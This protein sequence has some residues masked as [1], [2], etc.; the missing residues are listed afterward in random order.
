[1]PETLS[2]PNCGAPLDYKGSDPIIRC[3]Y[4]NTSVVVPENLR[5]KPSFSSQPHNFTL[6]GSGDMAGLIQKARRI[7]EVRDLAQSGKMDEAVHLY[8]EITDSSETDAQAAVQALSQGRPITLTGFSAVDV[9]AQVMSSSERV[10]QALQM[11]AETEKQT[12]RTGCLVGCFITGL[13]VFILAMVFIPIFGASFAT[14]FADNKQNMPEVLLTAM[15][16]ISTSMPDIIPTVHTFAQQD[17]SFGGE[18]TGAGLF[19]DP[20]AIAV[21]SQSG[22]IYVADYQGGRVQAFD[23]GGKFLTQWKVGDKKTII[24]SLAADHKG[25][26][27][28]VSST[29]IYRYDATGKLLGQIKSTD[30]EGYV[31]DD[32]AAS[33]DGTL[34]VI[35]GGETITHMD[36][37]G[38]VFKIVPAAVSTVS[39]DSELDSKIAVD[40]EGNIYLLG[41]FNNAVFKFDSD[42]KYINKF[43]G[44]GDEP[45]Q[46]HAPDT[47]AVDG[48][49][50]IYVSDIKGIQVF[51]GDGRYLDLIKFDGASFGMAFD[52]QGKLYITT[53]LNK[54]IKFS[55]P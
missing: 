40:G 15:P 11:R 48:Q 20:R 17:L 25:N 38:K 7:K 4:C 51:D 55:I 26:V 14:M 39:G 5:A 52:D 47:I 10:N 33:A 23:A 43:G 53:N 49:G 16:E 9:S 22:N 42:G 37:K 41:T 13:T 54:I 2:C 3:P 45:G 19:T 21:D 34:Y 44:D 8:R 27:F 24:T 30:A 36:I 18:G 35:G 12:R 31:L 28:V 29:T 46:F 6:S 50:R 1:M 32:V